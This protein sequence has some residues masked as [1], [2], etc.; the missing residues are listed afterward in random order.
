M[1]NGLEQLI[2]EL[3]KKDEIEKAAQAQ[4]EAELVPEISTKNTLKSLQER[5]R[6]LE[7]K[8]EAELRK[9]ESVSKEA[10]AKLAEKPETAALPMG[11]VGI[12]PTVSPPGQFALPETYKSLMAGQK[13]LEDLEKRMIVPKEEPNR[14]AEALLAALPLIVGGGVGAAI[15]RPG[16]LGAGLAAGGAAGAAGLKELKEGE[17]QRRL[18]TQKAAEERL[19]RQ[20]VLEKSYLDAVARVESYPYEAQLIAAKSAS[21]EL[22][23]QAIEQM[24]ANV[25]LLKEKATDKTGQARLKGIDDQLKANQDLIEKQ[26]APVKAQG[27]AKVKEPTATQFAAGGYV[28]RMEQAE[29]VFDK[30]Q[31]E[32]YRREDVS[33]AAR[34]MVGR[35]IPGVM[36][37]AAQQQKQAERNFLTAVLRRESGAAISASEMASGEAQYFDR[38]GDSPEVKEQKRAN[39]LQAIESLKAEAGEAY[40]RIPLIAPKIPDAQGDAIKQLEAVRKKIAE[41]EA[42]KGKK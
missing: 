1:A 34:S 14:L 29:A 36:T 20:T 13:R 23:K 35:L 40:K 22:A 37:P 8:R 30:L 15:G 27:A 39:R 2:E 21:P 17:Q 10:E 26:I 5:Q 41:L 12:A 32:G 42:K 28:K 11:A 3:R 9:M 19:Q 38:V 7:R 4:S 24:R 33:E 16:M 31:Q 6:V 25:A 18:A